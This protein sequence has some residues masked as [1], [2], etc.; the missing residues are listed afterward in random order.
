L[1]NYQKAKKDTIWY[2]FKKIGIFFS[3]S[4]S[5]TANNRMPMQGHL[6]NLLSVKRNLEIFAAFRNLKPSDF[7]KLNVPP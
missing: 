3:D 6:I 7:L 2:L 4:A 1:K 5:L